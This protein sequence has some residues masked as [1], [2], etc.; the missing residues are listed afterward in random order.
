MYKKNIAK[1]QIVQNFAARIVTGTRKYE[2]IK[3][4]LQQ[5]KW[6]PVSICC[7]IKILL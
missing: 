1:L 7:N 6:L 2:H 5:L 3:P 4:V